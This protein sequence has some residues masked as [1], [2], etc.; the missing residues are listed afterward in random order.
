MLNMADAKVISTISASLNSRFMVSHSALSLL[1][2]LRV[3]ASD[4]AITAFSRSLN[5]GLVFQAS[6][7]I[8]AS[9]ASLTPSACP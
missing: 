9:C 8:A 2:V 7:F 3:T 5:S 6:P 4:Q 1:A